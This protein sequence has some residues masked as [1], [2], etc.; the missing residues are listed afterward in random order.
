VSICS[1]M[2]TKLI[3]S[4]LKTSSARQ[5][6]E[7]DREK[8]SKRHTTTTSNLRAWASAISRLSSGRESFLPETPLST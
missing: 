4:A 8:R 5:R 3:F 6:W 1:I 7:T 2:D